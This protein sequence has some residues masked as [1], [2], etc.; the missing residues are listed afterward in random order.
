[1]KK[2]KTLQQELELIIKEKS[3]M[4]QCDTCC[5]R[6]TVDCWSEPFIGRRTLQSEGRK[7]C[8]TLPARWYS[9]CCPAWQLVCVSMHCIDL[10]SCKAASVFTMNL[11][12]YL[13]DW[14]RTGLTP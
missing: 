12:T 13:L 2:K 4:T 6:T 5:W 8:Y 3:E 1:M 7:D 11:L 14:E 9:L 10:F